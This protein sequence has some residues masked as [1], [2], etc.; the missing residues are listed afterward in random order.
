M[1]PLL[2]LYLVRVLNLLLLLVLLLFLSYPQSLPFLFPHLSLSPHLIHCLLLHRL[3]LVFLSMR[4][5]VLEVS[6]LCV[7]IYGVIVLLNTLSIVLVSVIYEVFMVTP[8]FLSH[9]LL[10]L[11]LSVLLVLVPLL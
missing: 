9:H 2:H 6:Q 1:L 4:Y 5:L 11:I 10:N 3:S 8:I 7:F